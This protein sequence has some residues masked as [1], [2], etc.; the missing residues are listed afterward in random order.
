MAGHPSYA[1][2][3]LL[4]VFSFSVWALWDSIWPSYIWSRNGD[5]II[6]FIKVI[7][8]TLRRLPELGKNCL[9]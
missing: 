9:K 7:E 3:F 5:H 4:G 1:L 8:V 6:L 2:S